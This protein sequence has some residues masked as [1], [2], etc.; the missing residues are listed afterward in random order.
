L[1]GAWT[2]RSGSV[3]ATGAA[4][5]L[6]V[7]PADVGPAYTAATSLTLTPAGSG[8][9][10][11]GVAAN[12]V[13]HGGTQSFYALRVGQNLTEAAA[14]RAPWQLIRVDH[15]AGATN[16]SVL[17]AGAVTAAAGTRLGLSI[18]V[19]AGSTMVA[20]V[21]GGAAPVAR[22]VTLRSIDRLAG[23]RAGLYSQ[24]ETN[25]LHD[26]TLHTLPDP[27]YVTAADDFER[28]D[29]TV[30]N[31]WMKGR[32]SWT[33]TGG[34]VVPSG[35]TERLMYRPGVAL[36]DT[37]TATASLRLPSP[38]PAARSWSGVAVNITDHG[39]GTQTFYALRVAQ[40]ADNGDSALWQVVRVTGS[41]PA[42]LIKGGS[43][44][45]PPGSVLNLTLTSRN[46]GT[47][48]EVGIT[49]AGVVPVNDFAALPLGTSALRAG[50]A[51]VYNN[52]GTL[53]IHDFGVVTSTRAANPPASFS[54]LNCATSLPG[55]YPLP[56]PGNAVDPQV[57]TVDSTWAGHPVGQA[58]L[59]SGNDQYVAYYNAQRQMT[60]AK[61]VLPSATWTR[62]TLD[63]TLGWDSH[64]Y[65][66][67]ALDSAGQ[68]HVSGNM[69]AVPLVYYRTARA[70]DVTSLTRVTTMVDTALERSVT[71]PRFLRDPDGALLY[72]FR[73]GSSGNGSMYYYRYDPAAQRWSPFLSTAFTDGEG[74]RNGYDTG[75]TRGPDGY[76]HLGIMWRDTPD[77]GSSSM[78]SYLRSTDLLRWQD[79][80]GNPIALPATYATA[81]RVDPV[82]IYGG[83]VNGNLRVGFDASGKVLMTYT[84]YDENL[85]N[86][87]YVA[88]PDGTGNWTRTKLTGFTGRWQ[89]GG[90]GTL[91]FALSVGAASPLPDGRLRVD[92]SCNGAARVLVVDPATMTAVADVPRPGLP[93]QI[94]AVRSTFPGMK[95]NTV[96]SAGADGTY[97][98]RWESLGSNQDQPRDPEDTPPP[99]PLQI[100]LVR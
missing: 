89:I 53:A 69:H 74:L 29:G 47:G 81:E 3:V 15:S 76:Y 46:I 82:P 87:I 27:G 97:V 10:W 65:V 9:A 85:T 59:T 55:D 18:Q 6:L 60:V 31:G 33:I 37:F 95:V 35:D 50:F 56:N 42:A 72:N 73:S 84:K 68:L 16:S 71:Y 98:L 7:Q 43:A 58:I 94:T 11:S 25:P 91:S 14:S 66:T 79:S 12:V 45:A 93:A 8:H 78:P 2:I 64:N 88:R 21:T 24:S 17:A 90:G 19:T 100:Y 86:Q 62:K 23:G 22:T 70:G 39:N 48:L 80:A 32:G 57:V 75:F 61:R 44:A 67:I 34:Q 77:A 38:A 49:G 20:R 41:G 40:A 51:G 92:Y 63:S 30:A 54:P 13:N 36:G 83:A 96:S 28:A 5:R 4:E 99:Q 52:A 1:R 26:F